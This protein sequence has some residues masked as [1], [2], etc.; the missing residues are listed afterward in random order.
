MDG[1]ALSL[2]PALHGGDIAVQMGGNLF[3]GIETVVWQ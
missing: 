2:L 1:H 3:P